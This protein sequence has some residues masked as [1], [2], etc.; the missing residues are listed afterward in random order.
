MN[1]ELQGIDGGE[2]LMP[3]PYPAYKAA[4]EDILRLY[5]PG[6]VITHDWLWEALQ[7]QKPLPNTR[8]EEAKQAELQYMKAFESLRA[9]ILEEHRVCLQSIQSVGYQWVPPGEQ[10]AATIQEFERLIGLALR[11]GVR[12]VVYIDHD[13]L[14]DDQRVANANA[15]AKLATFAAFKRRELRGERLKQLR[16]GASE[17]A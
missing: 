5:R 6:D 2:G 3:R 16:G 15:Q 12:N 7:L 17:S 9:H 14:S 4:A 1:E 11:K 13:S 8:Y 10:T